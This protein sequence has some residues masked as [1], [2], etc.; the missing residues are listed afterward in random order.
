MGNVR[1]GSGDTPT[2]EPASGTCRIGRGSDAIDRWF[3]SAPLRGVVP[4]IEQH[5]A[6][7]SAYLERRA[8]WPQVIAAVEDFAVAFKD[9]VYE[10]ADAGTDAL[11]PAR[12]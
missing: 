1:R 3:V 5:V 9:S 7:C 8:Q 11:H 10:L 2:V 4:V 12:D 6:Q